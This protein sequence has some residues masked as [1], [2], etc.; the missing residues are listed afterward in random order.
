MHVIA[1]GLGDEFVKIRRSFQHGVG[2]RPTHFAAHISLRVPGQNYK[3]EKWESFGEKGDK[4]L[5]EIIL[6]V[7]RYNLS[8]SALRLLSRNC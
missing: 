4:I 8:E 5:A 6:Q 3:L 1:E 7:P 2:R